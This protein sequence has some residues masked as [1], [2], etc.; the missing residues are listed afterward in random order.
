MKDMRRLGDNAQRR[1]K[2]STYKKILADA[3][4]RL[5]IKLD[6]SKQKAWGVY[7]GY[8]ILLEVTKD[9]KQQYVEYINFSM[10]A[11]FSSAPILQERIREIKFP[12][13]VL[14]SATDYCFKVKC[15]AVKKHEHSVERLVETVRALI[16]LVIANRGVSCDEKGIEGTPKSTFS[17]SYI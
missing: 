1:R 9:E 3:T 16:D 7:Q 5:G 10:C 4:S 2:V 13:S 17:W 15:Y 6:D 14:C 12:D 8:T 11:S